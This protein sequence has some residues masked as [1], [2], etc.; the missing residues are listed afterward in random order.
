[1]LSTNII[2]HIILT[3]FNYFTINPSIKCPFTIYKVSRIV[4]TMPISVVFSLKKRETKY[5]IKTNNGM[6]VLILMTYSRPLLPGLCLTYRVLNVS[7]WRY[8]LILNNIIKPVSYSQM[9]FYKI[10]H[11]DKHDRRCWHRV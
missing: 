9:Y 5:N 2:L 8:F 3:M 10:S 1:M 7:I 4:F 6:I 11:L